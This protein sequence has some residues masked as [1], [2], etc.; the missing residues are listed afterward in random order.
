MSVHGV[1]STPVFPTFLEWIRSMA[2]VWNPVLPIPTAEAFREEALDFAY[3]E[4]RADPEEQLSVTLEIE[5]TPMDPT[6][7]LLHTLDNRQIYDAEHG[8]LAPENCVFLKNNL[9]PESAGLSGATQAASPEIA[10]LTNLTSG[11]PGL[12]RLP[13]P[14]GIVTNLRN[15]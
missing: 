14:L 3:D 15:L 6:T 1:H 10:F 11:S 12:P 13:R 8:N 7:S 9:A 2:E 5:R 4:A